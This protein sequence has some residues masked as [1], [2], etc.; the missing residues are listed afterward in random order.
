MRSA[1]RVERC[2]LRATFVHRS[3]KPLGNHCASTQDEQQQQ[4]VQQ[5]F[6]EITA[7]HVS[8][9]GRKKNAK[10]ANTTAEATAGTIQILSHM[11]FRLPLPIVLKVKC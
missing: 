1:P 11:C 8:P 6:H 5:D 2:T 7:L 9:S 3:G 10:R 4:D